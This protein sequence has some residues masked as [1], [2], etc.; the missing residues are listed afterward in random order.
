MGIDGIAP[1]LPM[2][3]VA[4][5]VLDASDPFLGEDAERNNRNRLGAGL[6]AFDP[7]VNAV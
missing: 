7:R 6:C 5:P 2:F 1:L 4:E 3:G